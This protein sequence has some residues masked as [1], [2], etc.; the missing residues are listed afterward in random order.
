MSGPT[1]AFSA[2]DGLQRRF[3]LWSLAIFGSLTGSGAVLL[4]RS[5]LW[6]ADDPPGDT[7]TRVAEQ[8]AQAAIDKA[9]NSDEILTREE[10]FRLLAEQN[11]DEAKEKVDAAVAA[12]PSAANHYLAFLLASKLSQTQ[13]EVAIDRLNAIV[14]KIGPRLG[15]S[16]PT[17]EFSTFAVASR[18]LASMLDRSGKTE[19]A[20]TTVLAAE[21]SLGSGGHRSQSLGATLLAERCRLL[22]KLDRAEQAKEHLEERIEEMLARGDTEARAAL[23][24]LRTYVGLFRDEYPDDVAELC[25]RVDNSLLKTLEQNDAR[26]AD[27]VAYQSLQLM[28]VDDLSSTNSQEADA[29]LSKL[30]ERAA[31][32][33]QRVS[34]GEKVGF[35]GARQTLKAARSRL[36]ATIFRERLLGQPAPKFDVGALVHI[37]QAQLSA[38]KGKVVLIDFWAVWCGPCIATFPHLQH[39]HKKYAERGLVVIGVTRA[40]GYTWDQESKRAVPKKGTT[41]DE[42]LAMLERFRQRHALE[43]GFVVTPEGSDFWKEFG[44]TGIPQAALLDQNGVIRLIRIGSSPKN[45]EALESKIEEL[46]KSPA[47]SMAETAG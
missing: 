38:L 4:D 47:D 13:P 30:E 12:D 28:H 39:L 23:P 3:A 15:E 26:L 43:H 24:E 20:L 41:L 14:Q 42:E 25:D 37:D 46:L 16:S 8:S 9:Q 5:D 22:V 31:Q 17:Q 40:Y 18:L 35:E 33:A 1:R 10:L 32:F 21:E 6:A 36:A 7:T 19:K 2:Q 45:Y 27:Y 11:F 29:L 44:V 34:E